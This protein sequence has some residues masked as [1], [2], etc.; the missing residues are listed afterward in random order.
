MSS[1]LYTLD[2]D[3]MAQSAVDLADPRRLVFDY[4]RRIGDVLDRLP[5]GPV[6]VL[7]IGG[8][9]MTLPRYVATTRPRSAQ[10]VLEPDADMIEQVRT[11]APLPPRS[12][13]K[14]RPV[15][16]LTGIAAVREASQD[17]VVLDAF[18][19][20]EVPAELTTVPF[21]TE[22]ARVLAPGGVLVANIADRAPFGLVR[23]VVAALRSTVGGEIWAGAEPAT[24]K[25]KRPGNV[26]LVAGPVADAV[27]AAPFGEPSPTAYRAFDPR[28]VSDSF[29]G[30]R[31]R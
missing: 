30:G 29:G 11:E 12:G 7:H 25:A 19:D 24:L 14:V 26:V 1:Q 15:D 20:A 18:R 6:R 27:G 4:V 16:G 23:D 3:G 28:A 9:A 17:V 21:F 31:P 10:I 13:I 8:A 5:P 22:V 2:L